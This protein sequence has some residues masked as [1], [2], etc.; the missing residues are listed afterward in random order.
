MST[1]RR[2]GEFVH[3]I[4]RVI[5]GTVSV[6]L[7]LGAQP[8]LCKETNEGGRATFVVAS[9]PMAFR[10]STQAELLGEWNAFKHT[11]F[12]SSGF[13]PLVL[14]FRFEDK[15]GAS[16]SP[17]EALAFSFLLS[18]ALDW[19]PGCYCSRHAYFTFKRS[20][21]DA[22]AAGL[23]GDASAIRALHERWTTTHALG[24]V[25]R[26]ESKGYT[27]ELRIWNID[28][29]EVFS[30][31]YVKPVGYYDLL[32]TMAVDAM[33]HLGFKASPELASHLKKPRAVHSESIVDL[34]KAAFAEEGSAEEFRLYRS[35]LARDPGF[36]EVRFWAANQGYWG[37]GN[38]ADYEVQKAMVLESY[39]FMVPLCDVG[40][41]DWADASLAAKYG[42]WQEAAERLVGEPHPVLLTARLG[43]CHHDQVAVPRD[44][45]LQA[46]DLAR[47]CPNDSSLL[48]VLAYEFLKEEPAGIGDFDMT[49]SLSLA[50]FQALDHPNAW[51][52]AWTQFA[53]GRSLTL[54]GKPDL[55]ALALFPSYSTALQKKDSECTFYG[56]DLLR[57]LRGMGRY[58][59]AAEFGVD[60]LK[61]KEITVVDGLGVAVA[62]VI[63]GRKDVQQII[64]GDCEQA[65]KGYNLEDVFDGYRQ[66]AAGSTNLPGYVKKD[67]LNASAPLWRDAFY[68]ALILNAEIDLRSG[69][70]LYRKDVL[71]AM[72]HAPNFRPLWLIFDAY[73]RRE[74]TAESAYF[75]AALEWLHGDDP[76]VREH[77]GSRTN[78]V[79]VT[80]LHRVVD[81]LKAYPPLPWPVGSAKREGNALDPELFTRLP[82]GYV[83]VTVRDLV[84]KGK[85][86]EAMDICLRA[87]NAAS[88]LGRRELKAHFNHLYHL[89]DASKEPKQDSEVGPNAQVADKN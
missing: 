71:A 36:A 32:G 87:L 79:P 12:E 2:R 80:D 22:R 31:R 40:P 65:L 6:W 16:G 59:E 30:R 76:W 33:G 81:S 15:T 52:I 72:A 74:P 88:D 25:L 82:L 63:A 34:G 42:V 20:E 18:F 60:F 64:R 14:P 51:K 69:T 78:S 38:Q 84:H 54:L 37:H 58:S 62:A 50:I 85:R 3:I 35:I 67:F 75:Y 57:A 17:E 26:K 68:D 28:A 61:Q 48:Q 27:G 43:K 11:P 73:E 89:A 5:A 13:A 4:P 29:R 47:R 53:L 86:R 56:E 24:G 21:K 8:A 46:M 83:T 23:D 41:N 7:G 45:L 10:R 44:Q 55:A 49:A 66:F 9:A 39:L 1:N 77:A 19:S 70:S